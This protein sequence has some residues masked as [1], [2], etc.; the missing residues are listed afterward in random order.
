[1]IND[2]ANFFQC[3]III[4]REM[5]SDSTDPGMHYRTAKFFCC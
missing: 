3:F 1:M 4:L 5:I 2:P